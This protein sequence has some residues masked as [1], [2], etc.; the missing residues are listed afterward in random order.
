[1]HQ[2]NNQKIISKPWRVSV[3][4]LYPDMFPGSLGMS[5]AGRALAAGRWLCETTQIRDYAEG[6]HKNVD[7]TPTGGGAGM[8][9]RPDVLSKCINSTRTDGDTRPLIYLSPRGKTL[10][11]Q[12]VRELTA[13]E[14]VILLCGRFEGVDQR[15]LDHENIEEISIGDYILSGGEVAA[16][17][18]L[19]ACVRLLPEVMGSQHSGE[20]E[21]FEN[22]LLE[23]PHYTKP[24][25]W[26]GLEAPD[27]LRSGDHGK[28]SKWRK[29]QSEKITQE[30]RPDLWDAY[31]HDEN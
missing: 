9:L 20:D 6:K 13:G 3:M 31:L 4:T 8:V 1:M 7:D 21:S 19:D 30:R 28:I 27:I 12:R 17:T 25:E 10:T 24:R 23:Y 29:Q 5:I 22:G 11:Q 26:Q 14:G 2:N 15:L 16:L 18:L